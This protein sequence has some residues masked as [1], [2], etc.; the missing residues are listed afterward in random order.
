ML[1]TVPWIL[2]LFPS[3]RQTTTLR[4]RKRKRKK[5][6]EQ[7]IKEKQQQFGA[8]KGVIRKKRSYGIFPP[9]S[10]LFVPVFF[11]SLFFLDLGSDWSGQ[12]DRRVATH[13]LTSTS[14]SHCQHH[15]M[16]RENDASRRVVSIKKRKS[17][18]MSFT[19]SIGLFF[20]SSFNFF[21]IF[22][23]VGWSNQFSALWAW[24]L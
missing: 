2:W 15:K 22:S 19:S 18:A 21:G 8:G 17:A 23:S 12:T 5:K 1:P 20:F 13:S 7:W 24:A 16:E 3:G 11:Q 9:F 6:S 4:F 14:S 10:F